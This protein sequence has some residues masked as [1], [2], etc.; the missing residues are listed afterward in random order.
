MSL[1]ACLLSASGLVP[2]LS[3][4]TTVVHFSQCS[5]VRFSPSRRASKT[6]NK[7]KAFEACVGLGQHP[8]VVVAQ[9]LNFDSDLADPAYPE[10]DASRQGLAMMT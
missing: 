5:A 2:T 7:S 8:V 10:K 4:R 1:R 3:K 6:L 9:K